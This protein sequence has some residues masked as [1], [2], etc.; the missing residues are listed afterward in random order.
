MKKVIELNKQQLE[1]D[2]KVSQRAKRLRLTVRADASVAVTAPKGVSQQVIER[3]IKAKAGW[4]AAKVA[5]ARRWPQRLAPGGDRESYAEH[6]AQARLVA[7]SRLAYFNKFYSL[8][9]NKISIRNQSSRWGS[10]S[11]KGNLNF[12]YKI[13]LIP[14]RV[15]DYIIVHELCHLKEFNHSPKFWRMVGQTIP[16]YAKLRIKL[17]RGDLTVA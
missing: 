13:A 6:K 9:F 15:A 5:Q 14:E 1:Y 8:K 11:R 16:D 12:N 10:C 17:K 4:I 2:F 7:E 3:F